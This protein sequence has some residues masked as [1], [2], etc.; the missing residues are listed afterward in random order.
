MGRI[1]PASWVLC[2]LPGLLMSSLASASGEAKCNM[3]GYLVPLTDTDS[4]RKLSDSIRMRFDADNQKKCELMLTSYCSNNVR[5]KDYSP[6]NL[7]AIFVPGDS[8]G[9]E[10][11]YSFSS[12]CKLIRDPE[13]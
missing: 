4:K 5:G 9:Q 8:P 11:E 13:N 7:K 1:L 12:R 10:I 2:L 3:T 6:V